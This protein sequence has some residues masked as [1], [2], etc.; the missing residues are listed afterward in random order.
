MYR[1]L[2]RVYKFGAVIDQKEVIP[3]IFGNKK[4]KQRYL[5][6]AYKIAIKRFFECL[7]YQGK[8]VANEVENICFFV[9]E[10]TTATNGL[11]EL[12][13]ALEEEL[14]N[15]TVN[16]THNTF[17]PPIFPKL[18]SVQLQY[19]NSSTKTLVRAADI[20]ANRLFYLTVSSKQCDEKCDN[21]VVTYLPEKHKNKNR[22]TI[23]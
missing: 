9:D 5:D 2:N 1:S 14:K 8:I 15:G 12:R 20:V 16:Y 6:Y 23:S 7:I 11:Y 10:H 19:C 3:E 21:F 18:K 13:Q 22:K 17:Y 4:S